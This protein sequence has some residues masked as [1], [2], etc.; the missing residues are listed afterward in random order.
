MRNSIKIT[1][2]IP[3]IIIVLL[4][5]AM[6]LK[7]SQDVPIAAV[8]A[9]YAPTVQKVDNKGIKYAETQQI[10]LNDP[11]TLL[12]LQSS[13]AA[14]KSLQEEVK[15]LRGQLT[16][17]SS[18]TQ[19][20]DRVHAE[21]PLTDGKYSDRFLSV[22]N[23]SEKSVIDMDADISVALVKDKEGF[24]AQVRSSNPYMQIDSVKSFVRI[25][26][27]EKKLSVGVGLGY[28]AKGEI[29]PSIGINYKLFNIL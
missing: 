7:R 24:V 17:G 5:L 19:F 28:N 25:P 1:S 12:K 16:E 22:S 21:V 20:N 14:I 29:L 13:D 26:K 10:R 2:L 15:R 3:Y 23:T 11:K 27:D 4:V 18:I 9:L 8:N 6:S